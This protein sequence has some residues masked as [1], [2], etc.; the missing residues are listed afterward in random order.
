MT[1]QLRCFRQSDGVLTMMIDTGLLRQR[2]HEAR[3][4]PHTSVHFFRDI[5]WD[6]TNDPQ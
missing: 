5:S 3:D 6:L 2:V 4:S 1:H